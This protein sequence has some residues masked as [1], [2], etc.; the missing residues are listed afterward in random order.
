MARLCPGERTLYSIL[1]KVT[2]KK[3]M[4]GLSTFST[5]VVPNKISWR[6]RRTF[7]LEGS[8]MRKRLLVC[9]LRS[10]FLEDGFVELPEPVLS[11]SECAALRDSMDDLFAGKF[12][13]NV[14]PDE[15][16]WRLGISR[17]D[18][19]REIVNGWKCSDVVARVALRSSL[20]RIACEVAGWRQGARL[21]QDDLVYKPA[22]AGGVG[23]HRDSAYISDNFRPRDDNSVTMWI[24][25]DDAD[26]ENGVIEY[27]R[28]SHLDRDRTSTFGSF[29]TT[30]GAFASDERRT[31]P[32]VKRGHAIIHHQDILHGSGPNISRNRPRRA[33]VL[34][35]IRADLHL[36]ESPDYIYGRYVLHDQPHL[37]HDSFFPVVYDSSIDTE[38][39]QCA[40]RR[41]GM[42]T[43]KD[44]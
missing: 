6:V 36:R 2:T 19:V 42:H 10:R 32:T 23:Y 31:V 40:A 41:L 38:F 26:E 25:L 14:F 35:F 4:T 27:L 9:W 44:E 5:Q 22:G 7:H 34:H 1:Y 39:G 20:G 29:H 15:W 24:A 8:A 3:H 28:G 12:D 17:D 21:A 13:N 30:N 43:K 11:D 18:A 37:V 33:L 16:H